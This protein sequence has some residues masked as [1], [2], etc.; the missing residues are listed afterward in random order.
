MKVWKIDFYSL[1]YFSHFQNH[2]IVVNSLISCFVQ[3]SIYD[4]QFN[5]LNKSLWYVVSGEVPREPVISKKTGYIYE[6]SLITK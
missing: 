2:F 3:V 6:K 4:K 5:I 1:S